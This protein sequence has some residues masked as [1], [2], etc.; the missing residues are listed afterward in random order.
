[1]MSNY[2]TIRFTLDVGIFSIGLVQNTLRKYCFYKD[3]ELTMEKGSGILSKP[4]YVKIRVPASE[5][6]SAEKEIKSLWN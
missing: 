1:M 4:I 3:Y 5:V 2:A 6:S